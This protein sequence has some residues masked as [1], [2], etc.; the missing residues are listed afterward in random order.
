MDPVKAAKPRKPRTLKESRRYRERG[1]Q[2]N[3]IG[4]INKNGI[5]EL[6]PEYLDH[7]DPKEVEIFLGWLTDYV[8]WRRTTL[9]PT[10]SLQ[11]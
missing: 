5:I 11:R 9:P 3:S 6:W 2:D 4:F 10:S 8:A 7:T 1:Y